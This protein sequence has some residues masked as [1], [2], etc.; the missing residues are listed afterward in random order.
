MPA[1]DPELARAF[2]R[3]W[4]YALL[5]LAAFSGLLSYLDLRSFDDPR[6]FLRSD[7]QDYLS[8][9]RSLA[10]GKGYRI[11]SPLCSS[12][13]PTSFRTPGYPFFLF[14][15]MKVFG[16]ARTVTAVVLYQHFILAFL[17]FLFYLLTWRIARVP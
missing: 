7:S 11:D 1:R 12:D 6:V 4:I 3:K 13:R 10:E 17:P 15:V 8:I 14:L 2:G 5:L 16:Q 9:A